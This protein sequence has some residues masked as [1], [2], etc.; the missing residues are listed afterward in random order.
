MKNV[1]SVCLLTEKYY[2]EYVI[3][4][5][6]QKYICLAKTFIPSILSTVYSSAYNI[7]MRVLSNLSLN[8]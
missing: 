5:K 6:S 1:N 4:Y 8:M 7:I 3:P 2:Y